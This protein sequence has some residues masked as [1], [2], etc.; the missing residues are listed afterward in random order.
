MGGIEM[1]GITKMAVVA[2][3]TGGVFG[4]IQSAPNI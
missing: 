4:M 1:P 2:A 3:T